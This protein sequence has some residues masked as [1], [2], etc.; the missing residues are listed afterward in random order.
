MASA[1]PRH[2][3]RCAGF[4]R[5]N[6][7][8]S[9]SSLERYFSAR[10]RPFTRA[11]RGPNIC[12]SAA[13]RTRVQR[14]QQPAPTGT[15]ATNEVP[16]SALNAGGWASRSK[17]RTWTRR[18]DARLSSTA[19][20]RWTRHKRMICDGHRIAPDDLVE[21]RRVGTEQ[22][23]AQFAAPCGGRARRSRLEPG[24]SGQDHGRVGGG[25]RGRGQPSWASG[26]LK[27]RA[28]THPTPMRKHW[29]RPLVPGG[30][31]SKTLDVWPIRPVLSP[32][33][34]KRPPRATCD[35]PAP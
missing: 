7:R 31:V 35:C 24:K 15:S 27:I 18:G 8:A 2:L 20:R 12:A 25:F 26:D 3:P 1:P 19:C 21:N 34:W 32:G 11:P 10:W 28:H 30:R 23:K 4:T 9:H 5:H 29:H 17:S 14:V 16:C 33:R 22:R 13:S 6:Y